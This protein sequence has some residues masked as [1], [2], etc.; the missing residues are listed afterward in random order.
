MYASL[1]NADDWATRGGLN[2]I[3]IT[4]K[5]GFAKASSHWAAFAPDH[6]RAEQMKKTKHTENSP[7]RDHQ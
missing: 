5:N 4:N 7:A 6:R 1:W 2:K 3:R